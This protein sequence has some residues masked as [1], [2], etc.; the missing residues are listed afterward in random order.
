M[1]LL[2][3][4]HP[5][6]RLTHLLTFNDSAVVQLDE[7]DFWLRSHHNLLHL[8]QTHDTIS[9]LG[10]YFYE[11]FIKYSGINHILSLLMHSRWIPKTFSSQDGTD[12]HMHT[13]T[14]VHARTHTHVYAHTHTHACTHT[15]PHARTH[16]QSKILI[17]RL[18]NTDRTLYRTDT[19]PFASIS[20]TNSFQ[21]T[22]L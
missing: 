19:S 10:L 13:H 9:L 15:H 5:T 6:A 1:T 18:A 3:H 22:N 2:S 11:P 7:G 21:D 20:W 14:H 8:T 17:V 16:T 12:T 4:L